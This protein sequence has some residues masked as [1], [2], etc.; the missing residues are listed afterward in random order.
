MRLETHKKMQIQ[1]KTEFYDNRI[2]RQK[3]IIENSENRLKYSFDEKER[4]N[5]ESILPAQ[6]KVLQNFEEE[7]DNALREINAGEILYKSPQLLS[8]NHVTV[9]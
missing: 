5:I 4:K 9:Y 2:N 7:K 1:R 3:T 6:R 8:L